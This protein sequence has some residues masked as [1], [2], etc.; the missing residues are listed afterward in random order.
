MISATYLQ[1][2]A[3]YCTIR[4]GYLEIFTLLYDDV[5]DKKGKST[6]WI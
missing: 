1:I 4:Q 2:K 3:G 6:T 5:S